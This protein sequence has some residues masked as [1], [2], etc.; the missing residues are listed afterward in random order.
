M[1]PGG[2][3]RLLPG[4]LP[5]GWPGKLDGGCDGGALGISAGGRGGASSKVE[6]DCAS[7]GRAASSSA[8]V[9]SRQIERR[10]RTIMPDVSADLSPHDPDPKTGSR[11]RSVE[12]H[13]FRIMRLGSGADS[14]LAQGRARLTRRIRRRKGGS[15]RPGG[16]RLRK[17]Q[18]AGKPNRGDDGADRKGCGWPE[19]V[20]QRA[21]TNARRQHGYPAG[22]IEQA[23]A[24]AA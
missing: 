18:Q 21:G 13:A 16:R 9:A 22:Q 4:K 17:R 11:P 12:G 5:G 24:G 8:T 2:R 14:P 15:G 3:G 23:E 1:P 10:G 7:A 20:P 6:P 19:T